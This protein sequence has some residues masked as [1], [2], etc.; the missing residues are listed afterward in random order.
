MLAT[1]HI[2]CSDTY[3]LRVNGEDLHIVSCGWTFRTLHEFS[4]ITASANVF[5]NRIS[6]QVCRLARREESSPTLFWEAFITSTDW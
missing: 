4:H 5:R 1:F 2:R 3:S 6:T